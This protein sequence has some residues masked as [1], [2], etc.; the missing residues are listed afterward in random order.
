MVIAGLSVNMAGKSKYQFQEHSGVRSSNAKFSGV[1]LA[2]NDGGG[3]LLGLEPVGVWGAT[4]DPIG[5]FLFISS[6]SPIKSPDVSL[7]ADDEGKYQDDL[8][9]NMDLDKN[10]DFDE[11]MFGFSDE[12][13]DTE[14]SKRSNRV[15][16]RTEEKGSNITTEILLKDDDEVI[17]MSAEDVTV[18][19]ADYIEVI[20]SEHNE[21]PKVKP[22]VF[23]HSGG[24]EFLE[25]ASDISEAGITSVVSESSENKKNSVHWSSREKE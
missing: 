4:E 17:N 13:V 8:D 12:Q 2:Q 1:P 24:I 7:A 23:M 5:E 21:E 11:V 20:K 6:H 10:M 9:E 25:D 3:G 22:M 18:E 19:D 15:D 16:Q 14:L